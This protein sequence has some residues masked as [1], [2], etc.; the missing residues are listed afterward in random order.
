MSYLVSKTSTSI[1]IEI[2]AKNKNVTAKQISTIVTYCVTECVV[3]IGFFALF[4]SDF[5]GS[6]FVSSST[7]FKLL[8]TAQPQPGQIT[9]LSF[10]S[11]PQILQNIISIS[12]FYSSK[13]IKIPAITLTKSKAQTLKPVLT[14]SPFSVA[15]I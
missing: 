11:L 7:G 5:I 14:V 1:P 12:L 10:S 4:S 15:F 6:T 3:N 13:N 8:F 2:K 9:A